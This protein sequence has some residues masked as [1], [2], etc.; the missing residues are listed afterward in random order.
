MKIGET[1]DA[2]GS[3]GMLGVA[4]T[5]CLQGLSD[6][7][8]NATSPFLDPSAKSYIP[9]WVYSLP[10]AER[11]QKIALIHEFGSPNVFG[12]FEPHVTLVGDSESSENMNES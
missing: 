4:N 11:D 2:Q 7:V 1:K 8:V 3:Y 5:P 12:G 9:S 10:P 6:A